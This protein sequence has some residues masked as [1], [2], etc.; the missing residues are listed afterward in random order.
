MKF[1]TSIACEQVYCTVGGV[2]G[3]QHA[4][5]KKRKKTA[6]KTGNCRF[7]LTKPGSCCRWKMLFYRLKLYPCIKDVEEIEN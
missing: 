6:D 7:D 2:L 4:L 1:S 5:F 3:K